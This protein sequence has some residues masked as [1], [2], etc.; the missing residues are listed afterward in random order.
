MTLDADDSQ[1]NPHTARIFILANGR[2]MNPDIPAKI[3]RRKLTPL[4]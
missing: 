2:D 1:K 4:I 3:A